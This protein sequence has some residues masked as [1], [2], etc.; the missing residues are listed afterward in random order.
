MRRRHELALT[1]SSRAGFVFL[2]RRARRE[3]NRVAAGI[4]RGRATQP[5][6]EGKLSLL[7]NWPFQSTRSL[8]PR[9]RSRSTRPHVPPSDAGSPCETSPCVASRFELW[10]RRLARTIHEPR[11][12]VQ[13]TP[14]RQGARP[15]WPAGDLLVSCLRSTLHKSTRLRLPGGVAAPS[16]VAANTRRRGALPGRRI[17]AA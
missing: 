7:A 8:R 3:D 6:G 5:D 11:A 15:F 4:R 1:V 12:K 16:S 14:A 17:R 13:E 10:R 2:R 9:S